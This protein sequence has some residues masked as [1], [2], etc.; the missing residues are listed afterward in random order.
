[1]QRCWSGSWGLW[2]WPALLSA[3]VAD[4]ASKSLIFAIPRERLPSW[5]E[6]H[7]NTGV[8]W[9]LFADWPG[10]VT[11]LTLVLIPLLAWIWWREYRLQGAVANLAFG[12]ILGGALGN[13]YDRVLARVGHGPGVRDFIHIDLGVW[14][15][16][17]FPTFN[18]ADSAITIG[19]LLLLAASWRP[20]PSAHAA[21]RAAGTDGTPHAAESDRP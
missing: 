20:R 14:P 1:M 12:L 21:D 10:L 8:A 4:L 13:G 15:L 16:D 9:S 6:H 2:F 11:L 17:P 18:L 3:L 19:F 7:Y 5:L